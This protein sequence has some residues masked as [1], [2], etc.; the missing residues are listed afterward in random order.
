MT[1]WR[2]R[3]GSQSNGNATS[4]IYSL[5]TVWKNVRMKWS[6]SRTKARVY[7]CHCLADQ[8]Y[9]LR[10]CDLP[11][12]LDCEGCGLF[13]QPQPTYVLKRSELVKSAICED[14]WIR[15]P[16]LVTMNNW[17]K[18]NEC[19][20]ANRMRTAYAFS[21]ELWSQ[22]LVS[23]KTMPANLHRLFYKIFCT[24]HTS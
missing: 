21:S 20:G 10:R 23:S 6:R 16:V 9:V 14:I 13:Q 19:R 5:S 8:V 18:L 11:S 12:V 1:S 4:A 24:K 17:W 22:K 2:K 15:C 7:R 3:C